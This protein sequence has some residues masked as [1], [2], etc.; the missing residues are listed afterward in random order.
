MSHI[1]FEVGGVGA[2]VICHEI[3]QLFV[4]F[5]ASQAQSKMHPADLLSCFSL[6]AGQRVFKQLFP[7]AGNDGKVG[8][9]P[10]PG[11]T[12]AADRNPPTAPSENGLNLLRFAGHSVYAFNLGSYRRP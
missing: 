9:S 8:I 11:S 5:I 1:D 12:C 3:E 7:G 2:Q 4:H 10:F 6:F